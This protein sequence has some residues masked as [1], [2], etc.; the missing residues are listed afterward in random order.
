[1]RDDND[2]L[3]SVGVPAA[4]IKHAATVSGTVQWNLLIGPSSR[5]FFAAVGA[6]LVWHT[7]TRPKPALFDQRAGS[8]VERHFK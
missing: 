3:K 6:L 7:A 5:M 4:P 8:L 1:M 2:F